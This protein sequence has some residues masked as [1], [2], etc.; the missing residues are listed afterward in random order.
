MVLVGATDGIGL[1][2]AV[3]YYLAKL[4]ACGRASAAN[5]SGGP[6]V[7]VLVLVG[8]KSLPEL[9]ALHS[10]DEQASALLASCVATDAGRGGPFV[11]KYL[12]VDLATASCTRQLRLCFWTT[13]SRISPLY[14]TARAPCSVLHVV[15]ML[16][17]C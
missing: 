11:T 9:T 17:G 3:E 16:A 1:A 13:F 6:A 14:A 15:I 8:R 2:L 10:G 5:A 12:Q 7:G 4:A